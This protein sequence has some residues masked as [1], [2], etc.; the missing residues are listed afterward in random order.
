MPV[1][2]TTPAPIDLSADGIPVKSPIRVRE[3][4]KA[5]L[6]SG[7]T[8]YTERPGI[9]RLREAVALKLCEANG[10][11]VAPED[12]V[13][14]T[15]GVQ[16]ALFLAVRALVGP[17]DE[18]IV[19]GP[20]LP[21]DVEIV[22]MV[23]GL[24]RTAPPD[25]GLLLDVDSVE[26]L[27]GPSTRV[28]LLRSPS[29]VGHQ[30]SESDLERIGSIVVERD[31]RVIAIESGE[32][33]TASGTEHLSI[34]AVGGL[35]PRTIT[36]NGFVSAGL[37]SWRVGYLAAQRHVMAPIRRLKHELSICSPAVS[38]H[39][40]LSAIRQLGAYAAAMQDRLDMRRVALSGA[41]ARTGL[42]YVVPDAGLYAFVKPPEKLSTIGAMELALSKAGVT[43]APGET[44]GAPGWI[45]LTL[46]HEPRVLSEAVLRLGGALAEGQLGAES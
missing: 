26:A 29:P 27:A 43:V 33:F 36:I 44:V 2:S 32:S 28:I 41:L 19:I 45:R 6:E 22:R 40:A 42:E 30:P 13:L 16:E 14:I 46:A 9:R 5:A 3:A 8:H 35:G 1:I 10:I 39:A 37:D 15:C 38:Q 34:G 17:G 23:G 11:A 18:V 25:E 7:A 31:L 4:A 21:S 24:P 12:E 20:A